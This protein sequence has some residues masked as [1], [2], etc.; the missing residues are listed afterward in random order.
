MLAGVRFDRARLAEAAS[1]E[2]I[3]ATD[4]ADLLVRHGIPFRDAHGVVAGLVR[5][6]LEHGPALSQPGADE[7]AAHSDTLDRCPY[8]A[9]RRVP[10]GARAQL[11]AESKV[12]EGGTA[13]TRIAE[14]IAAARSALDA[15]E[16]ALTHAAPSRPMK[17]LTPDFYDRP[18][19]EVAPE[20]I[21]R[22]VEHGGSPA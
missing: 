11:L 22:T 18:V 4:V 7:L 17:T 14:Q 3:A 5:E 9:R 13:S 16:V 20:L 2:L 1:D 15:G 12:S 21:G 19:L 6:A 8:C 10:R